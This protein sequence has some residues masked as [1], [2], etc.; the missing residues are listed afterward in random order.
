MIRSTPLASFSAS[1]PGCSTCRNPDLVAP[2]AHLQGLRV[3]GSFVDQSTPPGLLDERFQRGSGTY[4][5]PVQM[6]ANNG[7]LVI[8]DFGRQT[9][10]PQA[11]L[12]RW[13]VPL[14]RQVDYLS[15]DYGLKF[16]VPFD[17]KIVFSTNLAPRDLVDEA[18][19]RR[20]RHKIEIGDPSFEEYSEIFKRVATA[21]KMEYD[22]RALG[23]LIQEY[24]IKARRRLRVTRALIRG[25]GQGVDLLH[26]ERRQR[27]IEARALRHPGDRGHERGDGDRDL[28]LPGLPRR[29]QPGRPRRGADQGI[30]RRAA[31]DRGGT[32]EPARPRLRR[33]AGAGARRRAARGVRKRRL[34]R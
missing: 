5:A 9:L 31:A 2:G 32:D 26:H 27:R 25:P 21:K 14:D 6:Q 30:Q 24:Y 33:L 29:G 10:S 1:G 28:R 23:Y 11:L 19:L 20:I 3:P 4:V 7:I 34:G 17:A 13:I 18:F 12:N 8:D 16:Q 22:E 15:L